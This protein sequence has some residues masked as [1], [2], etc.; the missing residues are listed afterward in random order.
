[1][2]SLGWGV[3][4]L[5]LARSSLYSIRVGLTDDIFLIRTELVT[6]DKHNIEE[7]ST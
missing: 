3:Y 5:A 2:E 1:M 7:I 4:S 6:V